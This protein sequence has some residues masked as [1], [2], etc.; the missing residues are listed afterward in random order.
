MDKVVTIRINSSL[1]EEFIES[2]LQDERLYKVEK[3]KFEILDKW[4]DLFVKSC[5]QQLTPDELHFMQE[6]EK[7]II[8]YK[9]K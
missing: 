8:K 9:I 7:L 5:T 2:Y 4:R 1:C 6:L 3:I